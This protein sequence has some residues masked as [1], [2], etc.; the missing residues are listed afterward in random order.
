MLGAGPSHYPHCF[1]DADLLAWPGI[2]CCGDWPLMPMFR[3]A[4]PVRHYP[5][6]VWAGQASGAGLAGNLLTHQ[7]L[8]N[9]HTCP[10][11]PDLFSEIT[12]AAH[13]YFGQWSRINA[14]ETN[15]QDWLRYLPRG[16]G[17]NGRVVV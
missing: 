14:A 10:A 2:G 16:S 12:Y 1:A 9:R 3:R 15:L 13:A 8:S 6:G 7:Q 5:E 17:H 11:V 4:F